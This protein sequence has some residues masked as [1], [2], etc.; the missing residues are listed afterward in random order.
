LGPPRRPRAEDQ[1]VTSFNDAERKRFQG[2]LRLA[3]ESPYLGERENALAAAHRLA[4]RHGMSIEEAAGMEPPRTAHRRPDSSWRRNWF[5]DQDEIEIS[6]FM[7]LTD[8]AIRLAKS[9]HEAAL[10]AARMRGLDA[11]ELARRAQRDK[12]PRP[13]N[14]RM[15]PREHARKLL[16]ETQLRLKDIVDITGLDIYQVVGLKLL[17]R[18]AA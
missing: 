13:N 7:H 14:R 15:E 10:R 1:I 4:A 5:A 17:L 12:R 18:R 11:D 6:R 16:T 3:A 2:L 9:Q 8:Y